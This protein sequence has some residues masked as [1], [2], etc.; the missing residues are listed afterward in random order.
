MTR[1]LDGKRLALRVSVV[2]AFLWAC[3]STGSHPLTN[4]SVVMPTPGGGATVYG[5]Y[6]WTTVEGCDPETKSHEVDASIDFDS[7]G[8]ASNRQSNVTVPMQ[9]PWL[10]AYF[11]DGTK[12]IPVNG[13]MVAHTDATGMQQIWQLQL[14]L[15]QIGD[16]KHADDDTILVGGTDHSGNASLLKLKEDMTIVWQSTLN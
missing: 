11:A 15:D 10:S 7:S 8:K 1:R 4:V 2:A 14:P 6:T 13:G 16:A 12:L 9:S 5:N 3:G